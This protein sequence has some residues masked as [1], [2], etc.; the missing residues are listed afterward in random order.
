MLGLG[1]KQLIFLKFLAA[2]HVWHK[3]CKTMLISD[4][5]QT[6]LSRRN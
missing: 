1:A 4:F 3:R 5:F 2:S 6:N